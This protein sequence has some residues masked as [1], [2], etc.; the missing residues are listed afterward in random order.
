MDAFF[1]AVEQRDNPQ[2]RGKPVIVGSPPSK[3]GVV[4]AA[5]YEARKFGVRSAIPSSTAGRLCPTGIFIPP[6]IEH[7]R[8]ESKEIMRILRD[9]GANI[10]PMSIDEAY[11]EL[12]VENSEAAADDLLQAALPLAKQLKQRIRQERQLTASVGIAANKFLAKLASDL[13]KPDGLTLIPE[14]G[15]AEFLRKFPVRAIHGVGA[16]TEKVLHGAGIFTMGDLQDFTGDLRSLVGSF[17]RELRNYS[18]GNDS[19]AL[20]L[21]D[22]VKSISSEETFARDTLDKQLLRQCLWNQALEIS[23]KLKRKKLMA[24]TV[25]IKLRYSNFQTLSRQ[26][27]VEDSIQEAKEIFRLGCFLLAREKLISKPIRLI[28]LGVA[29]I[30]ETQLRQLKLF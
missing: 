8:A 2:L 24:S 20:E 30:M 22:E 14:N 10:E 7:Y 27:T 17:S 28:G 6:R 11:M 23:E 16:A 13:Q 21:G 12:N 4:C 1:A 15:K 29:G 3:R 5:S 18:F 26:I 25:Q 9:T 19:R